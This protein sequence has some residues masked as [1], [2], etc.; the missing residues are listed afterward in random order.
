[1]L[2]DGTNPQK[3]IIVSEGFHSEILQNLAELFITVLRMFYVLRILDIDLM[4][5]VS[6]SCTVILEPS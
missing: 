4:K 1:M 5:Y 6:N 2:L 3:N